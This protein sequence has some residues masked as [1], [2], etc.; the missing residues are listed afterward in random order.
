MQVIL[1]VCLWLF[2][3]WLT[4]YFAKQ[5]GRDEMTW[6]I[7]GMF[8]GIIGLFLVFI[9]PSIKSQEEALKIEGE[10]ALSAAIPP[11]SLLEKE[12]L[13]GAPTIVL[14]E[15][16]DKDWY[17]LDDKN[18]QQ[19]PVFY[20]TLKRILSRGQL[21]SDALVWSEGMSEWKRVSDLPKFLE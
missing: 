9:L 10:N 16:Q 18:K 20:T 8:L 2:V 17:Y 11:P 15:W 19:G 5:R 3:G 1:T 13:E 4:S 6:F 14:N 21:L 12:A 7:I